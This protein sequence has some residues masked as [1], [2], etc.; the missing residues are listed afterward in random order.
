MVRILMMVGWKLVLILPAF[1]VIGSAIIG[2]ASALPADGF[3]YPPEPLEGKIPSPL[4]SPISW[5][6]PSTPEPSQSPAPPMSPIM[7]EPVPSPMASF[8]PPI[9]SMSELVTSPT[10]SPMPWST[11]STPGPVS[12]PPTPGQ[13]PLTPGISPFEPPVSAYVPLPSPPTP[14]HIP[15]TPGISPFEPPVSAY[16]P[17]PSP[18][19]PG[20]IPSTPGISPFEPPGSAYVPLPSPGLSPSEPPVPAYV[21]MSA[22]FPIPPVPVPIASP[23]LVPSSP[24]PY[25]P[26]PAPVPTPSV[27]TPSTSPPPFPPSPSPYAPMPVPTGIKGAYW[28]SWLAESLPPV[29]IPTS[30]FTH[31]FYAFVQL[32]ASAYQLSITQPDEQWM[33]DPDNRAAFINSTIDVARK[34]GFDG[35]DLDWE[36]PTNPQDMS[37]LAILYS[38]WHAAVK[39]EAHYSGQYKLL[40][41]SAVYFASDFFLSD[42]PRSYPADAIKKYVDFVSPMCFDYHGSWDTSVTGAHALLYDKASNISTSYGIS[43]WIE[44]GVPPEKLVMGLPLYGRTW[45]L[46]DQNKHGIGDP[47]VGTGPGD[48]IMAYTNIVDFNSEKGAT[49]VYDEETVST[50]SYAGT[51]WIG[52]DGPISTEN[53]VKFAWEQGLGGYF[54]W[55]LGDDKNWT[56]S[57]A[58]SKAWDGT[59]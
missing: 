9:P 27:P 48:G 28:P 57:K 14:G 52:Y 55:A 37:N 41:S 46:K 32:D 21:P 20:H 47:A 10:A 18:P 25:A 44:A 38:E 11:P 30:Y 33:G 23:P 39:K 50:Y 54:L 58:A 26:M 1:V 42:V 4:L 31:L 51:N 6:F 16:V 13:I 45:E 53:K 3:S 59:D 36:F 40:L 15:S 22:L 35:L 5:T 7:P 49:V 43:S 29:G 34:Y 12:S 8:S 2:I 19:T 17:L 56:L 24:S